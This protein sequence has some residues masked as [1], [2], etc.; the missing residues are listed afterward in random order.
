MGSRK[1]NWKTMNIDRMNKNGID[2]M[3]KNENVTKKIREIC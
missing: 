1:K 3:N 2:R